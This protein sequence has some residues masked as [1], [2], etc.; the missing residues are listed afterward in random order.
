MVVVIPYFRFREQY[1]LSTTHLQ[2]IV[3]S[4]SLE[5]RETGSRVIAYSTPGLHLMY[6]PTHAS[7]DPK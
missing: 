6:R 2:L 7:T 1:T 4:I 5:C 3:D